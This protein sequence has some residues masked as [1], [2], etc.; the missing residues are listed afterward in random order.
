MWPRSKMPDPMGGKRLLDYDCKVF[1]GKDEVIKPR[2]IRKPE[3]IRPG[4]K[5]GKLDKDGIWLVT[6]KMP[7]KLIAD[8]YSGTKQINDV[9]TEGAMPQGQPAEDAAMADPTAAPALD[10][11]TPAAPTEPA[12]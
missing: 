5:K 3:D 8:I 7:K 4:S 10:A 2:K 11:A 9:D 12:I 1:M 6:I